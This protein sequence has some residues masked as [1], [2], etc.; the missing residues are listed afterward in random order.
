MLAGPSAVVPPEIRH[1]ATAECFVMEFDCLTCGRFA[2]LCADH[3]AETTRSECY[4]IP[5]P[6]R[7]GPSLT[8]PPETGKP[9]EHSAGNDAV[10]VSRG[11]ASTAATPAPASRFGRRCP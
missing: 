1:R 7:T 9:T 3:N 8:A 6:E 10:A 2:S 5:P 11:R 4:C